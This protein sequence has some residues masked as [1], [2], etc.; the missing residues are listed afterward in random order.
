MRVGPLGVEAGAVAAREPAAVDQPA[1]QDLEQVP[2][3]VVVGAAEMGVR[4]VVVGV[5]V[6][7][8]FVL[9]AL[10]Q[11]AV[12]VEDVVE[13]DV[14]AP[15]VHLVA[16]VVHHVPVVDPGPAVAVGVGAPVVGRHDARQH[17][18]HRAP[19][20]EETAVAQH[21]V[22]HALRRAERD[23]AVEQAGQRRRC[24][25]QLEPGDAVDTRHRLGGGFEQRPFGVDGVQQED[26]CGGHVGRFGRE[27]ED[28]SARSRSARSTCS[29][30]SRV[31]MS[32][33]RSAGMVW[34]TVCA[35]RKLFVRRND[36]MR[37]A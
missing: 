32:G 19:V 16:D 15:R 9:G 7:A 13:A 23:A 4:V 14:A 8:Q 17:A 22:D 26:A 12:H 6:E 35:P 5:E 18:T 21:V 28:G 36:G 29:R 20:A 25:G 33:E 2:A 3:G 24:D 11:L 27:E 30:S 31:S 10:D 1:R 37:A 34:A